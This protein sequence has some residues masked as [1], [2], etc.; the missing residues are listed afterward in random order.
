MPTTDYVTNI[1]VEEST[2]KYKK[3][4]LSDFILINLFIRSCKIVY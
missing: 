1:V 4:S 3:I 2:R